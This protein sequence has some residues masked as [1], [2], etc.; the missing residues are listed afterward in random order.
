MRPTLPLVT[1]SPRRAWRRPAPAA[2]TVPAAERRPRPPRAAGRAHIRRDAQGAR[3]GRAAAPAGRSPSSR[4]HLT[5][6]VE[7]PDRV[8]AGRARR[9]PAAH[10]RAAAG[11]QD[12]QAR[13]AQAARHGH[14]VQD[15]PEGG[16]VPDPD[17]GEAAAHRRDRV[18]QARDR[19]KPPRPKPAPPAPRPPAGHPPLPGARDL[20]LRR[21][22][23]RAS[24]PAAAA[25]ATRA[26]T[27]PPP[28]ARPWWPRTRGTREGRAL[29]GRRR[30]ALRGA[31]RRRRGPRL[32]VHA[33][34]HRLDPRARGPD[35]CAPASSWRRWATPGRSFGAHL[36]FEIW[37][38]GGWYTGGRPVDPLPCCAPG[39][40]RLSLTRR[41]ACSLPPMPSVLALTEPVRSPSG[42]ANSCAPSAPPSRPQPP[43]GPARAREQLAGVGLHGERALGA[44]PRSASGAP[45]SRAR[46]RRCRRARTRRRP[47]V[48]DGA[49]RRAWRCTGRRSCGC[50]VLAARR[51][52][53]W[54]AAPWLDLRQRAP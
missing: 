37:T 51:A 18:G 45:R 27:S 10:R 17:H 47:A 22:R 19:P 31:R 11:R 4:P 6:T 53:R 25:T 33:P 35:A 44:R 3:A 38:G 42:P 13:H 16:L 9:A 40:G 36:H 20:Q 15:R 48:G 24:A 12:A 54:P 14:R 1:L 34:G 46:R 32:R 41:S 5:A 23:T 28:R 21:R 26:R 30:R 49:G 7:L 29:P 39:R 43:T 52:E 2:P 50:H 8:E